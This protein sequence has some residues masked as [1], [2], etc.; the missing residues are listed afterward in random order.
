MEEARLIMRIRASEKVLLKTAA[1]KFGYN[2]SDYVRHRL[3]EANEDLIDTEEKYISPHAFKHNLITTSLL[4]K[5]FHLQREILRNQQNITREQF[6]ELEKNS[7]AYA[8]HERER[9]GYK[10]INQKE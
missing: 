8:R 1:N 6:I 5:I 10:H 4:L 2:L 9:I 7:L 3:L